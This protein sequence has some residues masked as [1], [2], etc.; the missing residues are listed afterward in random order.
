MDA[1]SILKQSSSLNNSQ[2]LCEDPMSK[3][4]EKITAEEVESLND[5]K[6][7]H[8][9]RNNV[10]KSLYNYD[11]IIKIKKLKNFSDFVHLTMLIEENK[12]LI[13]FSYKMILITSI[14][15]EKE[16]YNYLKK[17]I[18]S[19]I[20]IRLIHNYRGLNIYNEKDEDLL[21]KN[22]RWK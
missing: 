13:N 17:I 20:I 15:E 11:E 22:R 8:L 18:A 21:K 5:V 16:N 9:N 10:L 12:D 1:L 19:I 7:Y 4:I 2:V 3:L 14:N 6:I